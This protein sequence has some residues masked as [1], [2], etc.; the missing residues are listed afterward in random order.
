MSILSMLAVGVLYTNAFIGRTTCPDAKISPY[1]FGLA[2]PLQASSTFSAKAYI[3]SLVAEDEDAASDHDVEDDDEVERMLCTGPARSSF[4]IEHK[5]Q[6][7]TARP[8]GITKNQWSS[9]KK[10]MK[11]RVSQEEAQAAT[12]STLKQCSKWYRQRP[13]PC[14][15]PPELEIKEELGKNVT[16]PEWVGRKEAEQDWWEYGLAELENKFGMVRYE[17]NGR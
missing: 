10:Q 13:A 17:W 14:E 6:A 5:A 15:V 16:L 7:D 12:G 4:P 9:M 8:P 2:E 11:R 1:S 3:A